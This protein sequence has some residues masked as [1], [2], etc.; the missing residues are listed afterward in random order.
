VHPVKVFQEPVALT[1]EWYPD[2]MNAI[3]QPTRPHLQPQENRQ[4]VTRT[5]QKQRRHP[6]GAV[7]IE[8]TAKLAVNVVLST[9]ALAALGQ[10]LPYY[11]SQQAK[12]GQ[13]QTEV[14]GTEKRVNRLRSDFSRY[15]DPEQAKSVMQEQSHRIDPTQRQVV[16]MENTMDEEP[17]TAP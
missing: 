13:I 3:Q 8:T 1:A 4:T 5:R 7:V 2:I 6:H 17:A 14:K 15:F 12:L 9:A 16:W 11:L 10:L